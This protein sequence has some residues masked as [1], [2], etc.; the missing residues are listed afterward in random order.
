MPALSQIWQLFEKKVMEY[1]AGRA[2]GN[3]L[4]PAALGRYSVT[5]LSA[6]KCIA[7]KKS[8]FLVT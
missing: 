3:F 2:T 8:L 7:I 6:A 4:A 5:V 1:L